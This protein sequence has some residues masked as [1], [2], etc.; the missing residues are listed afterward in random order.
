MGTQGEATG[1]TPSVRS[2]AM[3]L[4]ATLDSRAGTAALVCSVTFLVDGLK[5]L[6]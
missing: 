3:A 4:C 5:G 6:L 1:K 2:Q